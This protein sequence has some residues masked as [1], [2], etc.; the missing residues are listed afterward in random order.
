MDWIYNP[1]VAAVKLKDLFGLILEG[2]GEGVEGSLL[3][4]NYYHEYLAWEEEDFCERYILFEGLCLE[5]A[6]DPI[7]TQD[8]T[9]MTGDPSALET[10]DSWP[11]KRIHSPWGASTKR[12]I[13]RVKR[14]C[15]DILLNVAYLPQLVSF[16]IF[17][18]AQS[19][20]QIISK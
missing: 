19:I 16:C 14:L 6:P 4:Y 15:W 10:M 13:V 17:F 3:R 12:V 5:M 18:N 2:A 1:K 7:R 8:L 9:E 11:I 20:F